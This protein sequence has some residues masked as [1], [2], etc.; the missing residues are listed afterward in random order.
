LEKVVSVQLVNHLDR[1][2]IIYE[3][4]FGFERGK[5]T[6]HNLIHAVNF[7]GNSM[8]ENKYC[9]GVFFDLKKAFD[10]CSLDVL[11]TKLERMG[12]IGNTLNWF[13]SYL[14][15][16]TQLVE[17]NGTLSSEK[18]I[19][20]CILQGSILGPI[21]F[22][23][24]INDL[25]TVSKMLTVMFADD[26]LGLKSNMD[27]NSLIASV[28]QDINKMAIWFKA[29]KLAVNKTKTKYIIF[30]TKGKRVANNIQPLVFDENE[31]GLPFN[32]NNII[33]LERYHNGHQNIECRA[34]KLLG[35]Y[36]D[37]NLTFA[38]HVN[39]LAKKLARSMYCIKMA[40]TNIN[41]RGLRSL[42]FALIHS[43][44]SYCP[45]IL[46]CLSTS[47]LNRL[48][49][50]QKKAIRIITGSAYNAHTLPLFIKHKILPLEKII[51]QKKLQFM[52][53]V[54]YGYAPKSFSNT[55]TSN[56]DRQGNYNLRNNG[57]LLL[58]NPRI[59]LYKKLP[60][61]SLPKE[62]NNSENLRFYENKITFLYA[63]R[64]QMFDE[65]ANELEDT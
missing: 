48:F 55:W 56:D 14:T 52:H 31:E 33:T 16:R 17:I 65:L 22:K 23:C 2:N 1:N 7:I 36:L 37:E 9:I 21:L 41:S 20:T 25:Y 51:K 43:H 57:Q 26:T 6:E 12:M 44:L 54:I 46:G 45:I 63:L 10:V 38:Y 3:H 19:K 5:S 39:Y 60:I 28:N 49:K 8:N 35:I 59:E 24:Y 18:E 34:Y 30:H 47:L 64:G 40:K 50:V 42:Y 62:W 4:Q 15:N 27:L 53:S 13:R 58:P 61:Y 11:L 29:N 32:P